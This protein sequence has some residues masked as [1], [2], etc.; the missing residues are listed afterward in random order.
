MFNNLINYH[1][2]KIFFDSKKIR[3]LL[4][5]MSETSSDAIKE[6]WTAN[7]S[8]PRCWDIPAVRARWNFL[9]SGSPDIDEYD[10][11]HN[12]YLAS[13]N[14]IKALSL[15]CG[16]GHCELNWASFNNI[17]RIDAY[18]LSDERI[19][20]A[21]NEAAKM[22]CNNVNFQVGDVYKIELKP[23]H[24]DLIIAE[25]ALHHFTPLRQI[26]ERISFTL[27]PAGYFF[28]NE[29]IG[30]SMFQ[31]TKN[32]INAVNSI[33]ELL[34]PKYRV[35]Y[36]SNK[37]K[38]KVYR[39]SRLSMK[40]SDPSEAVE[41]SNIMPLLRE[42][43]E[44]VETKGYGGTIISLLFEDIAHNFVGND[45]CTKQVLSTCFEIEDMLIKNKQIE[46][47]YVMAV[48]RKRRG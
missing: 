38:S 15:A 6:T 46:N 40:L 32:Q 16:T 1:D 4:K 43:F 21:K 48:C 23:N 9:M 47:D 3:K 18:D 24:Y 8:R 36:D 20:Y 29:F 2:L 19:V 34:P 22:N 42:K 25:Q 5:R 41:S 44:I 30:P 26:I 27:K 11:I 35:I 17:N 31:W 37:L 10:Y 45:D 33:L 7:I 39:P 14:S 28:I 12:K 13:I